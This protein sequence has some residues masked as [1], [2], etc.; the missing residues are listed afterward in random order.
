MTGDVDDCAE[1]AKD[2]APRRQYLVCF[3]WSV[4]TISS[5]GYGDILPRSDNER[6]FTIFAMLLGG[7]FYGYVI[8]ET[9]L[10]VTSFDANNVEFYKKLDAVR[11]W[12][13]HHGFP[14]GLRRK[15]RRSYK[16]FYTKH[17]ALDESTIMMDLEPL[18]QEEI[19]NFL[20]P[21]EV[22]DVPL[23]T[24]M[25]TGTKS[26][27]VTIMRTI[28]VAPD[29]VIV[30]HGEPSNAMFVLIRGR[31]VVTHQ[32]G[33]ECVAQ[34][35]DSFGE[36]ALLGLSAISQVTVSTVEK[37]ELIVFPEDKFVHEFADIPEVLD[38]LRRNALSLDALSTGRTKRR[39]SNPET[40]TD[41]RPSETLSVG[42]VGAI[43][44]LAAR[45]VKDRD[46][47]A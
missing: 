41:A 42:S 31:C 46:R 18:L 15:V 14:K 44:L 39:G 36:H 34:P 12:M 9:A 4:T 20:L 5:V 11:C 3:Y 10:I 43:E 30:R 13:E 40:T 38:S 33:H 26:K 32:V 24:H 28:E 16:V 37:C 23:F 19:T 6:V 35:G 22:Q 25:P 2:W 29:T 8:G 21:C 17:M 47:R 27:L 1:D 7:A 45:V